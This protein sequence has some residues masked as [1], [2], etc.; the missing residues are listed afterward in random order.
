LPD[1]D[2][3]QIKTTTGKAMARSEAVLQ[4]KHMLIVFACSEASNVRAQRK[5]EAISVFNF[6]QI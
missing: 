4:K 6:V 5:G 3:K 2:A 1:T